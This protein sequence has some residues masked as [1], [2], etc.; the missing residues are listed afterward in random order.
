MPRLVS[1]QSSV[2][3]QSSSPSPLAA[4]RWGLWQY[5]Q[6]QGQP[7][8]KTTAQRRPGQSDVENGTTP[9]M[10]SAAT[11]SLP[12]AFAIAFNAFPSTPHLDRRLEVLS[13]PSLGE[14]PPLVVLAFLAD[15]ERRD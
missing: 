12:F 7:C 8:V 3:A 5:G 2:A 13:C 9:P 10:R 11:R 1:S 4:S 14:E 15:V 6:R